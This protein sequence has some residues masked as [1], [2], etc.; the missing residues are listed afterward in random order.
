M[1]PRRVAALTSI[2]D[3]IARATTT[4]ENAER[5]MRESAEAERL[6]DIGNNEADDVRF[7]KLRKRR[8][9]GAR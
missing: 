8:N 1:S 5:I 4:P 2:D 3:I 7:A 6:A 9:K